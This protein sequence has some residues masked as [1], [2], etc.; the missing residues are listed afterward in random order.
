MLVSLLSCLTVV[1]KNHI[2]GVTL[3]LP[4]LRHWLHQALLCYVEELAIDR[5][6]WIHAKELCVVLNFL[7]L[8]VVL[9]RRPTFILISNLDCFF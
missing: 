3:S 4:W 5:G 9:G 1:V 7:I 6:V 2:V 8:G